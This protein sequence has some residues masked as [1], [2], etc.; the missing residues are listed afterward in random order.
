MAKKNSTSKEN[1]LNNEG[2]QNERL[3]NSQMQPGEY[4]QMVLSASKEFDLSPMDVPEEATV[5]EKKK[6]S[7][8]KKRQ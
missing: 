8:E 6:A 3:S 4:G 2:N 1:K 7:S 5:I